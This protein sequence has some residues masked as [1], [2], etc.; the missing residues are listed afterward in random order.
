[1]KSQA[2]VVV[3]GGRR[4]RR[5]DALSSGEEGVVGCRADR[6]QGTDLGLDLAC[7]R[8]AAAVQYELFGQPDSQIFGQVLQG[9]A[10]GDRH[11]CRLLGL[12][13]IRLAK[14]QD[15]W[16]EYMYYKGVA[17]T[18]GIRVDVLTPDQV[19][20]IW[21]LCETEGLIGA[22]RHP[23]GRLYPA[24]RPDPGTGRR[25]P[26]AR[27]GDLPLHDRDR[28]RAHGRRRL[29]GPD[30]QGRHHLRTCRLGIGQFRPSHRR[31]GR[32]RRAGDSG[33]APVYRHR[34]ASRDPGT[35]RA[36]PAGDGRAAGIG[37]ILGTCARKPVGPPARPLREGRALLLCRRSVRRLG[38]RTLPGRPRT[39]SNRISRPPWSGFPPSAR[40]ASR[41]SITAPSP[42]RRTA[43][44]HRR[45]PAWDPAELLAQ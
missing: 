8:A 13:N 41:R 19:K 45:G 21:P 16:D 23:R 22:I 5:L 40:S 24:R 35:A 10:A 32:A 28:H 33:R 6:A 11:G 1:M 12:L 26:G 34:T 36:G 31:H 29:A 25:R 17:D 30:R 7:G 20:E 42:I 37:F 18:L 14:T 43:L 44:A 9:A 3:I 2:R 38:I 27:G 15:R 4:R 39:G